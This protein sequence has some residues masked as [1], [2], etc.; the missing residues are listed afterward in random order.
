M[1]DSMTSRERVLGALRREPIDRIPYI[2]HLF[3]PRV[4]MGIAAEKDQTLSDAISPD[5][6]HSAGRDAIN[7]EGLMKSVTLLEPAS[8]SWSAAKT[9]RFGEP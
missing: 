5:Q 2:E 4:A 1:T 6:L 8:P 3:D 7:D 9:F